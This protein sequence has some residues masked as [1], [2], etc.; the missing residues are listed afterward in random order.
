[1]HN[2]HPSYHILF[3]TQYYLRPCHHNHH[4]PHLSSTLF[5]TTKL[6]HNNL[7][8]TLSTMLNS[9]AAHPT[10]ALRPNIPTT[11]NVV[12]YHIKKTAD[13][14]E[15]LL[16]NEIVTNRTA[17]TLCRV[18]EAVWDDA[19]TKCALIQFDDGT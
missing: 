19:K 3:H 8:S 16:G 11:F 12:R 10:T 18:T 1:M 14:N 6:T 17:F 2:P 13:G 4:S 9:P 7:L 5:I 15:L